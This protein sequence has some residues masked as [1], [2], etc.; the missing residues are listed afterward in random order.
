MKK[1]R[2][3]IGTR[4]RDSANRVVIQKQKPNPNIVVVVVVIR[5]N[6][7]Q[8]EKEIVV[9][10][11]QMKMI[12]TIMRKHPNIEENPPVQIATIRSTN[13]DQNVKKNLH[14][15]RNQKKKAVAIGNIKTN[16]RNRNI[17]LTVNQART[18][19]SEM[20]DRARLIRN[21]NTRKIV[22]PKKNRNQNM[23]HQSQVKVI[24]IQANQNHTMK[25]L[26]GIKKKRKNPKKGNLVV[27]I[28][29][30]ERKR[31]GKRIK[32]SETKIKEPGTR[33][34]KG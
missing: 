14:P 29:L 31:S 1:T 21:Q 18:K 28:I 30:A 7:I 16:D 23:N 33:R 32:K 13:Q 11:V 25:E 3:V 9:T 24:K 4:Q 26:I 20:K 34:K 8:N 22:I 17:N 19:R 10:L 27:D 15:N 12:M 2:Q 5:K 6:L